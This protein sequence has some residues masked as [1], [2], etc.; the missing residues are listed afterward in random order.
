MA[1]LG[2]AAV[3]VSAV[4]LAGGCRRPRTLTRPAAAVEDAVRPDRLAAAFPRL[5]R[6]H[7]RGTARFEAAPQG[8]PADAVTTETDIWM[9][10]NG[11]WRLVELND[12]DGGR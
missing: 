7:L 3:A 6:A 2:L 1:L 12:K 11:N 10:D 9:D 5:G 4:V 8:G